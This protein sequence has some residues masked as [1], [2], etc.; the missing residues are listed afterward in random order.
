MVAALCPKS[1]R[2]WLAF[3]RL[4]AYH[5]LRIR[6]LGDDGAGHDAH[7]CAT[8]DYTF[9]GEWKLPNDTRFDSRIV[10]HSQFPQFPQ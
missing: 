3:G 10:E 7:L 1:Q 2:A 4:R 6:V 5:D 9:H 8:L